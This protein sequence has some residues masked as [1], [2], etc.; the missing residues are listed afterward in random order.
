MASSSGG[1]LLQG[2]RASVT[3]PFGDSQLLVVMSPRTELGGTLL[4]RLW[5]ILAIIGG[6]LTASAAALVARLSLRRRDAESLA[7][8]NARLYSRQRSV[9]QTLQHSLLMETFPPVDGLDFA[10]RYIAGVDGI[11]IG[12]DWYDVVDLENGTVL[13]VVGD[14]SGRGLEAATTMASL[15]YAARGTRP[16][17]IRPAPS[18]PSCRTSSA[19]PAT[20]TSP[21]SCAGSTTPGAA[22]SRSRTPGTPTRCW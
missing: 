17:D 6:L 16:K 18:S 21:P 4:A 8:E 11:D 10:A 5:W 14:V 9:A 19:S 2:R 12:G 22:T 15:R 13:L 1:A 20:G 7:A 3:V